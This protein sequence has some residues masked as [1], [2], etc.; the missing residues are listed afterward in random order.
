[1]SKAKAKSTRAKK[2]APSKRATPAS[3]LTDKLA[4][5]AWA[6][7]DA[8]LAEALASFDEAAH[9]ADAETREAAWTLLEQAL[10]QAARKR[11]LARVGR[12]GAA[13]PYDAK[14][15]DLAEPVTRMPKTV[16][17]VA[18]GVA[19]GRDV[20]VKPRVGLVRRKRRS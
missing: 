20:L 1:M 13:E 5:A 4:A 16:R 11:G 15:H 12:L 19:R 17:V 8:A 18:R 9:A 3:D 14:K 2:R 10:S 7:A 6:E